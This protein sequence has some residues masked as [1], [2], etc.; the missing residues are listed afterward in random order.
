MITVSQVVGLFHR[1][2]TTATSVP[3][4][5]T[6]PVEGSN[7]TRRRP[8]GSSRALLLTQSSKT[9]SRLR[10]QLGMRKEEEGINAYIAKTGR[11][12]ECRNEE[13]MTTRIWVDGQE[14]LV[15]GRPDG[16]CSE[17]GAIIEHKYRPCGLLGHVPFHEKVQCHLYMKMF[18]LRTAHLVETFN[19]HIQIHEVMFDDSVWD[20]ICEVLVQKLVGSDFASYKERSTAWKTS[21]PLASN[22]ERSENPH[23]VE[24]TFF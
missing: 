23:L 12:V 6:P 3:S 15:R 9:A 21:S 18:G 5:M 8:G 10:A 22:M 7:K 17:I 20:R 2:G 13:T 24:P 4:D 1:S 14:V 19:M 11:S 16:I